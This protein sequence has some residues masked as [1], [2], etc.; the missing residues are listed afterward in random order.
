MPTSRAFRFGVNAFGA[1]SAEEW[2]IRARRA[3][4]LG[5]DTLVVADHLHSF[6]PLAG[7]LAAA[8]ATTRLRVGSLTIGNDFRHPLMLARELAAIDHFSGG[9]LE[10]G[11]GTGWAS[12]DYAGSGLHLDSPS[13]RIS[14]LREAI[15]VIKGV[16]REAPFSFAGQH[17]TIRDVTLQPRP[18]ARRH[19]PLLIGGGGRR[20]LAL[21]ARE[22]DIV[23]INPR[24]TPDG[25][26]DAGQLAVD[27]VA[28][29]VA[30][31]REEAGERFDELE[32]NMLVNTVT[33]TEDRVGAAEE[34][35]TFWT[36]A[37]FPLTADLLL[38]S[39]YALIGTIEQ[40]VAQLQAQ[41]DRLHISY[42]VIRQEQLEEFAPVVALLCGT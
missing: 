4:E 17:Y 6:P 12:T 30:W 24:A 13:V 26:F 3:E 5:Y 14:R 38:H 10:L 27:I 37:G 34:L 22:A 25:G 32:L 42:I 20:M 28:A 39:P 9:R 23:G 21:A 31:V 1:E 7:M 40:I 2:M 33:V 29:Q 11:L 18:P 36:R 15:A 41:R 35:A 16:F 19:P 8:Q